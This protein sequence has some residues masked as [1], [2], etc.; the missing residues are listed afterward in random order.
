MTRGY[1]TI[2]T[3]DERYYR[4]ARNLLRSYRQT[5]RKR[6]PFA[7]IADRR[8]QYTAEFDDVVIL[9]NPSR[10]WMDK[11]ALPESCPYGETIFVD[12]DCLVYRD[13][14]YLWK[15]FAD[16][17]DFSCFGAALP[18]DSEEG[19]FTGE[20]EKLYPIHFVT[21]LHGVLYF[22]RK[23]DTAGRMQK[24]CRKLVADYHKVTYKAFNDAPA[25]E[26]VFALA[27][28]ILDLKPARRHPED[29]CFAPFAT[30]LRTNFYKR[31]VS[32]TNPKDGRVNCCAIVHWGNRNTETCRYRFDAH[33]VNFS[34]EY[35]GPLP[36]AVQWL[37][38]GTGSLY[39]LYWL[40]DQGRRLSRW[41]RWFFGRVRAKILGLAGIPVGRDSG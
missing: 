16:G 38:Y 36:G 3:G 29:Y 13:I 31:R 14:G 18:L 41:I 39:V 12:A 27:M 37:L 9:E 40:E 2:A 34:D 24:L 10:C 22:I 33:A 25:D 28:A 32:Y 35:R 23:G 8:N 7:L 6:L 20:A 1:V 4:M 19:W 21:H 5:C 17:P 15:L 11:L 30:E 26:P